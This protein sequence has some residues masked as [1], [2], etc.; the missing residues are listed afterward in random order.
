[1]PSKS[2]QEAF[3][4]FST[5]KGLFPLPQKEAKRNKRPESRLP[6]DGTETDDWQPSIPIF[7]TNAVIGVCPVVHP[8]AWTRPRSQCRRAAP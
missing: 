6:G 5:V 3:H 2:V 8:A 1:M 7:T 4:E